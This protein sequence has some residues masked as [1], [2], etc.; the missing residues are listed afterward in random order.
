MVLPFKGLFIQYAIQSGYHQRSLVLGAN[1]NTQT[2]AAQADVASVSRKRT[3]KKNEPH[4]EWGGKDRPGQRTLEG[5]RGG[6]MCHMAQ[7]GLSIEG[8]KIQSGYCVGR[9]P[10][11]LFNWDAITLLRILPVVYGEKLSSHQSTIEVQSNM[12][13]TAEIS[14]VCK[15]APIVFSYT[16]TLSPLTGG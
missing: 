12:P 9:L 6:L 7:R 16:S 1:R 4:L 14:T 8:S 11:S 10:W 5:S 13:P 3:E 2:R 15:L